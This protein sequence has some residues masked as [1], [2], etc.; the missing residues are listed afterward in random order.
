MIYMLSHVYQKY[1]FADARPEVKDLAFFDSIE[2]TREAIEKYKVLPGFRDHRHS[3]YIKP[4]DIEVTGEALFCVYLYQYDEPRY[5]F[6]FGDLII[7]TFDEQK[8]KEMLHIC[9]K[10]NRMFYQEKTRT[11]IILSREVLNEMHW[12]EGFN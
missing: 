2:K 8:A 5:N 9:E 12:E 11:E 3:F 1:K 10:E 4:I 7:A 6:E